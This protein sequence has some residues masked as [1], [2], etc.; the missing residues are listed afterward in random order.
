[1]A[2]SAIQLT[3]IF[4]NFSAFLSSFC[5]SF[6]CSFFGREQL[7]LGDIVA[8]IAIH[9]L[10]LLG[11]SLSDYPKLNEWS[12][13]L[14][15]RPAWQKTKLSPEDFEAFKR[16]VRVLVKLR[17]REKSSKIV[18]KA[19]LLFKEPCQMSSE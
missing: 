6:L 9:S 8:G 19:K 5:R 18:Q 17:R 1:M 7:T 11:V 12:E 3:F 16:R 4:I 10:P 13:R 2:T 15:Q 14:M